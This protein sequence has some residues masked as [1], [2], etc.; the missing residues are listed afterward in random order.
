MLFSNNYTLYHNMYYILLIPINNNVN[1]TFNAIKD[2]G[3]TVT[4]QKSTQ[5][6]GLFTHIR[7]LYSFIAARSAGSSASV[8]T[9]CFFYPC[10]SV[11]LMNKNRIIAQGIRCTQ[12]T[13]IYNTCVQT[14]LVNNIL[15]MIK[16]YI[17]RFIFYY[18]AVKLIARSW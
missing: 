7:F 18:K 16:Y 1:H 14:A 12:Y 5:N 11:V 6:Q 9:V 3:L 2:P 15:S 13:C 17:S 10:K 8:V 4:K